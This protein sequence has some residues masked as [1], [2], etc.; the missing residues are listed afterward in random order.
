M[1]FW[2]RSVSQHHEYLLGPNEAFVESLIDGTLAE[3]TTWNSRDL[4]GQSVNQ[5]H[6]LHAGRIATFT[7]IGIMG[8][9]LGV[10]LDDGREIILPLGVRK[11]AELESSIVNS[12]PGPPLQYEDDPDL[13]PAVQ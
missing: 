10:M 6:C 2:R 12:H 9:Q 13:M 7:S 8:Y 4:P 1:T 3:R 5:W 11:G